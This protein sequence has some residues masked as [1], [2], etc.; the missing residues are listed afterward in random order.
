MFSQRRR[1]RHGRRNGDMSCTMRVA[2]RLT[3]RNQMS[4]R[5]CK[6]LVAFEAQETETYIYRRGKPLAQDTGESWYKCNTAGRICENK[7]NGDR[8]STPNTVDQRRPNVVDETWRFYPT[9][10]L[11]LHYHHRPLL[12]SPHSNQPSI[13]FKFR[14]EKSMHKSQ[15]STSRPCVSVPR[16][17]LLAHNSRKRGKSHSAS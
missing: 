7:R 11:H 3:R 2:N 9:S 13:P 4:F 6:E 8:G 10:H 16:R 14:R 17:S 1:D 12:A 5:E 15:L